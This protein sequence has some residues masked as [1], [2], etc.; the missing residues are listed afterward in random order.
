MLQCPWRAVPG[1]VQNGSN[2]TEARA[3]MATDK[4]YIYIYI[5]YI[6]FMFEHTQHVP[7]FEHPQHVP[8]FEHPQ[9]FKGLQPDRRHGA[10][11]PLNWRG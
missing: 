6:L 4:T 2:R 3:K 1:D 5:Y 10:R 11:R 9:E 7:L 8:L